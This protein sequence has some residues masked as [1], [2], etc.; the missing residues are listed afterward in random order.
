[1]AHVY[2]IVYVVQLKDEVKLEESRSDAR[3]Y[4]AVQLDHRHVN[5]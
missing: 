1:M 4:G 3:D 2:C 5:C